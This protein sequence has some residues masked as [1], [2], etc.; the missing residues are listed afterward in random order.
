MALF[1]KFQISFMSFILP[2]YLYFL[3]LLLIPIIIHFLFKKKFKKLIFSSTYLLRKISVKENK[4]FKLKNI[5][6]IIIRTL[7]IIL[8]VIFFASP[9]FGNNINYIQDNPSIIYIFLDNSPSMN[10]TFDDFNL[11]DKAKSNVNELISKIPENSEVYITTTKKSEQFIGDK[12]EVL[13]FIKNVSINYSE[14]DYSYFFAEA[15]SFFQNYSNI[16][17]DNS[18]FNRFIYYFSDGIKSRNTNKYK[19]FDFLNN[20]DF[21]INTINLSTIENNVNQD[22][23]DVSIDSISLFSNSNKNNTS[24]DEL[25]CYFTNYSFSST[26]QLN[27]RD[28]TIS[29]ELY[30]KNRKLSTQKITFI[31]DE[32]IYKTVRIKLLLN[33]KDKDDSN[34]YTVKISND[35]NMINNKL[36]FTID[37][38]NIPILLVGDKSSNSFKRLNILVN[39]HNSNSNF[40]ISSTSYND[41]NSTDLNKYSIILLD[42][43]EDLSSYTSSLLKRYIDGGNS[44]FLIL[45]KNLSIKSFNQNIATKLNIPRI[46]GLIEN[47]EISTTSIKISNDINN[48]LFSEVFKREYNLSSIEI[49]KFYSFENESLTDNKKNFFKLNTIIETDNVNKNPLLF[50][51]SNANNN[52]R[53]MILSTSLDKEFSNIVENGIIVPLVNNSLRYLLVGNGDSVSKLYYSSNDLINIENILFNKFLIKDTFLSLKNKFIIEYPNR[54]KSKTI[55]RN[56]FTLPSNDVGFYH[57]SVNDGNRGSIKT[58]KIIIPVNGHIEN[59]NQSSNSFFNKLE[60]LLDKKGNSYTHFESSEK[61]KDGLSFFSDTKSYS[62]NLLYMLLVLILSEIIIAKKK[63]T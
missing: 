55:N 14:M 59:L 1:I 21:I 2:T 11:L 20:N 50:E 61:F 3:P 25:T 44:L 16:Y 48:K 52:S 26:S 42:N 17:K 4:K 27:D 7:I 49:H 32:S 60:L 46:K 47:E 34:Y 6:L 15:D 23:V 54:K 5:L 57:L 37:K 62:L 12:K 45:G 28:I 29:L 39:L 31:K 63:K 40:Q 43:L 58:K 56:S 30:N 53:I 51:L 38:K 18:K 19:N 33:I 9:Y 8:L 36:Y 35:N 10:R 24:E 13:N 41:L 22:Y